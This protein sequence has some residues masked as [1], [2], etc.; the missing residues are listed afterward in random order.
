MDRPTKIVYKHS[1][2]KLFYINCG[3]LECKPVKFYQE[4]L[5]DNYYGHRLS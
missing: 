5:G 4:Q 1:K 2:A 3:L